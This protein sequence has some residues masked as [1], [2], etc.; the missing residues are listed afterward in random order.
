MLKYLENF[1]RAMRPA[2]SRQATFVWFVIVFV[3]FLLRNDTFG[4]SSIVRALS[5][6]PES[7]TC[8]LHFF[9]STAWTVEELMTLWWGWLAARKVAYQTGGRL[10][11]VGDHTKAPKDGRKMPAVTTLHQDSE[12]S[13][14]PSFFRGHHWG[15]IA[16][17]VQACDKF[18]AT[19]LWAS[20]QEGL[21]KLAVDEDAKQ[22]KTTRIVQMAQQVACVMGRRAYLVLDAY[23]A[24]GPVF[25]MAAAQFCGDEPLIHILT[26]AKKNVVAYRPARPRKKPK[27]GRPKKYG[28]KLKLMKLFDSKA[29]AF[30]FQTAEA[31]VYQKQEPIRYLVLDLLWKPTKGMLR[32]ILIESSRGRM[33]LISSD[34]KLEAI[35]AVDLYSR[36]VTIETMFDTLKNTLGGMAYHFWSQYLSPASRRPR[37][38]ARNEP[39]SSH[40]LQT[41]NTLDAIEKF[42]NVLLLVLG[43][44]QLIAKAYPQQVRRKARCWLRTMSTYTPSEFVTRTALSNIIRSNLYGFG[45]D[46]ITQLIRRAQKHPKKKGIRSMAA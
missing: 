45:K 24:V 43:T 36:R 42:V 19:P 25:E 13:G 18:F 15:C 20:I 39:C 21:A 16:V 17:V 12:T 34:L 22:P 2:F 10:V 29:K 44:L 35:T 33:I 5:L 41:R 1:L 28:K 37:K 11:L 14:K 3:G 7:Y 4:V 27:R 30:E 8:L 38:K 32:F 23:F 9:H 26:R 6:M 31:V 40:P 46:W